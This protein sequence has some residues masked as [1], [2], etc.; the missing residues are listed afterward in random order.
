MMLP[1]RG[2]R[3]RRINQRT[4]LCRKTERRVV[5]SYRIPTRRCLLPCTRACA[6]PGCQ[7]NFLKFA[8]NGSA[9]RTGTPKRKKNRKGFLKGTYRGIRDHCYAPGRRRALNMIASF[10]QDQKGTTAIEYAIIASLI[11]VVIYEVVHTVGR[12]LDAVFDSVR[13]GLQ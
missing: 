9:S 6:N 3:E 7:Q 4:S 10:V 1:G 5:H 8:E 11:A 2:S 13:N 12:N